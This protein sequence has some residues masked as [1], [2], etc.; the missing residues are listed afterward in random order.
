M[1]VQC[2]CNVS[3]CLAVCDHTAR[4]RPGNGHL[5]CWVERSISCEE[6]AHSNLD[7]FSVKSS[8]LQVPLAYNSRAPSVVEFQLLL[9]EYANRPRDIVKKIELPMIPSNTRDRSITHSLQT[10][11]FDEIFDLTGG[12]YFD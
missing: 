6:H 12:A 5:L 9:P 2:V 10:L 8:A 7:R 11:S 3:L 4:R 1:Y